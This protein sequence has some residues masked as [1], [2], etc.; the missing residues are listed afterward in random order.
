MHAPTVSP[1]ADDPALRDAWARYWTTGALH[2]CATSFAA[3]YDG[4]ISSFWRDAFDPLVG[5]SRVLD[6]ATGNG[7]LPKLLVESTADATITCDAVDLA[8]VAPSWLVLLPVAQRG[9]AR[10]HAGTPAESLP[11]ESARFALAISQFGLEY[12]DLDRSIAELLRVMQRPSR[13]AL[14]VHHAGSRLVEMAVEER[15][16]IGWMLESGGL[17]EC[18][19]R[20][21]ELMARAATAQGRAALANDKAAAAARETFNARQRELSTRAAGSPCPDLLFE[22][23]DAIAATVGTATRD[24]EAAAAAQLEAVRQA[25][26]D[27]DLRLADLGRA[28]LDENGVSAM[29]ARFGGVRRPQVES[30]LQD[31]HLV[32]WAVRLALD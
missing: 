10:F 28:A 21:L 19:G 30:L 27:N 6:I 17:F 7:A 26:S 11:F 20:I 15:R 23:R 12:T 3:N 5:G 16:H 13:V 32:G 24:G 29:L 18:T 8:P 22:L 31:G 4:S 14:V 1:P 2:S 9:R 25:V